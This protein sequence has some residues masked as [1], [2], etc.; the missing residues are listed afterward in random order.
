MSLF[1]LNQDVMDMVLDYLRPIQHLRQAA[2]PRMFNPDVRRIVHAHSK[3]V[4][5]ARTLL[6]LWRGYRPYSDMERYGTFWGSMD[7]HGLPIRT[8]QQ[9]DDSVTVNTSQTTHDDLNECLQRLNIRGV[10]TKSKSVKIRAIMKYN[11][12]E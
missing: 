1:D 5:Y 2:H 10:K 8:Y 4:C 6:R 7:I 12:E 9:R 3:N 11:D